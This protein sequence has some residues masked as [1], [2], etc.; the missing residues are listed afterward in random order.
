M[1]LQVCVRDREA[2]L[3]SVP[4]WQQALSPDPGGRERWVTATTEE[5]WKEGGRESERERERG[6]V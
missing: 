1:C 5:G 4:P 3:D 2:L 6:G